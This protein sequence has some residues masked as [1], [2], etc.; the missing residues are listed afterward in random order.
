LRG[1]LLPGGKTFYI[2]DE[3]QKNEIGP[4]N[5]RQVLP[6]FTGFPDKN[7]EKKEDSI[8]LNDIKITAQLINTDS[9]WTAQ[10]AQIDVKAVRIDQSW[11]FEMIPV[12]GNQIIKLG[13]GQNIAQKISIAYLFF[14][15]KC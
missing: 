6:V 9:F 14:I 7:L 5:A 13:N 2:D 11:E 1:Y 8:L 15:R 4:Q 3:A 12:V 10:V